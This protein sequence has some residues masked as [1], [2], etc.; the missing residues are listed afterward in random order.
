MNHFNPLKLFLLIV[1]AATCGHTANAEDYVD[2]KKFDRHTIYY[3]V[4]NSTFLTPEIAKSYGIKRSEY[5][6]L[7]NVMVMENGKNGGVQV[8]LSGTVTNLMQQQ[9][10]LQFME[11]DEQDT[12]YYL[13]PIRVSGEE[14]VHFNIVAT[15]T[16]ATEPLEVTF[17]KKLYSD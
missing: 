12:V 7:I 6:S 11:I 9:K 3:T 13:A 8:A 14:T 15:P 10:Q 2:S 17:T 1:I 16:G 4:F 5:E